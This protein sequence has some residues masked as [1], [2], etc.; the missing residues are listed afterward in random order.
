M[1]SAIKII[2]VMLP[3]MY[4]FTWLLYLAAFLARHKADFF[5]GTPALAVTAVLH[6]M[7]T[8]LIG[9]FS[10]SHPVAGLFE[11]VSFSALSLA[12]MYLWIERSHRNYYQGVFVLPF[13][14]VLQITAASGISD[15]DTPPAALEHVQFGIHSSALAFGYAALFLSMVY[16]VMLLLFL[17]TLT[18]QKYG[19]V[20]ERLPS[21]NELLVMADKT[22]TAGFLIISLGIGAGI[23]YG[24]KYKA[25]SEIDFKIIATL[26]IWLIYGAAAALYK[27]GRTGQRGYAVLNITAFFILIV[28][29]VTGHIINSGW[30]RFGG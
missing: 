27:T 17:R 16:S 13:I 10:G 14:T 3:L 26:I 2:Q 29:T 11:F 15:V 23:F 4:G 24:V 5:R 7:F 12:V 18:V 20:F 25:V 9:G 21:L 1:S 28:L 8:V 6:F 19:I 30:H 22:A